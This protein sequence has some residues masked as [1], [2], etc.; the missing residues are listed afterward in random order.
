VSSRIFGS[1]DSRRDDGAEEHTRKCFETA[2]A[3]L[4]AGGGEWPDLKQLTVYASA[5][6]YRGPVEQQLA[7]LSPEARLQFLETD[8]GRRTLLPRLQL[9]ALVE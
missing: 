5:P 9:L 8:L 6:E 3:L 2:A 7:R 4:D 1:A